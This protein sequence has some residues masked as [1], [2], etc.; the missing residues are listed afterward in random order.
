MPTTQ[1]P[2]HS[3][4]S[5]RL[6]SFPVDGIVVEVDGT[7][8]VAGDALFTHWMRRDNGARVLRPLADQLDRLLL[9]SR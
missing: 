3:E 9:A 4:R 5:L 6:A 1:A 7:E 2:T 8:Y